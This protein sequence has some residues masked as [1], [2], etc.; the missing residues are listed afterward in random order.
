MILY[1]SN[2]KQG[3]V[4]KVKLYHLISKSGLS[5]TVHSLW[6]FEDD[7]VQVIEFE[8]KR[9][10][11]LKKNWRKIVLQLTFWALIEALK[12]DH[13]LA[14]AFIKSNLQ[15]GKRAHVLIILRETTNAHWLSRLYPLMIYY[16][17]R[18]FVLF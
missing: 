11:R 12:L 9:L 7:S 6:F 16:Q 2:F 10:V 8:R 14:I 1:K 18:V 13:S 15:F 3:Y 5:N 4:V 17:K